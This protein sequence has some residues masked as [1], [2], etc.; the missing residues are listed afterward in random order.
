MVA[1]SPGLQEY[2][3]TFGILAS[4]AGTIIAAVKSRKDIRSVLSGYGLDRMHVLLMVVVVLAFVVLEIMIVKPTQQLFFDDAIYQAMALDL[5][6]TGQAWMCNYGTMTSCF[7]GEIFHE[8]I[9]ESFNLAIGFLILGVHRYS[10]YYTNFALSAIAVAFTYLSALVLFGKRRIALLSELFI[11]LSPVMLVWAMPTTSDMP[12]L[13]Y[14]LISIFCM[15]IFLRKKTLWTF[16]LALFSLSLLAY[17]K[18]DAVV[19]LVVIP[20]MYV[21]LDNKGIM[22]SI[23]ANISMVNDNLFNTKALVMLLVFAMAISPELG[24]AHSELVGGSFGFQG[25]YVQES[26]NLRYTVVAKSA[27]NLQNFGANI[28]SNFFFWFDAYKSDYVMQPIIFT[29]FGIFGA[30]SMF[31]LRKR[32]ELLALGIWF[33]AFFLIY[34]AFYAGSVVYG[35][36]WRFMLSLIA[37]ASIFA[38]FGMETLISLGRPKRK[39]M[40]DQHAQ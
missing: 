27:I 7:S 8:P 16:G 9:G 34:T 36:D 21:V 10:A 35:V 3:F 31:I 23:K 12:M 40:D 29:A 28:C 39:N 17:M 20:F 33:L 5:L 24:F 38:G 37:Q 15:L 32:R 22:P 19:Y 11:A 25:A 14:S 18:V 30:I 4:L 13:A 2:L 1:I 6:H 26:C